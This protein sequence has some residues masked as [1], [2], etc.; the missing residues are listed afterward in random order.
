MKEHQIS[1]DS[2]HLHQTKIQSLII[3]WLKAFVSAVQTNHQKKCSAFKLPWAQD[4]FEY[5][6]GIHASRKTEN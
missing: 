1:M 3:C 2:I 6:P 5:V 4:S